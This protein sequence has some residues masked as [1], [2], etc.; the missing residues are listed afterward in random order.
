VT[1]RPRVFRSQVRCGHPDA[2]TFGAAFG[3]QFLQRL[4][5]DF[6]QGRSFEGGA[7]YAFR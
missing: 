4:A 3:A 1:L 2:K 7:R 5:E 6:L